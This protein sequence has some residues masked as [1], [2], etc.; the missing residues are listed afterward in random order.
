MWDEAKPKEIPN[1][2]TITTLSWKKDGSRLCAV[3]IV[4]YHFHPEQNL[5]AKLWSVRLLSFQP[6]PPNQEGAVFHSFMQCPP[7]Y[8]VEFSNVKLRLNS[9]EILRVKATDIS[10]KQNQ[11]TAEDFRMR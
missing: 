11:K 2:Y 4:S 6:H 8:I 3:N 9:Y 1:L 7:K 5:N 10:A